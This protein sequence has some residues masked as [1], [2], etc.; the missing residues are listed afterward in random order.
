MA[1]AKYYEDNYL[2]ADERLRDIEEQ[3]M[4]NPVVKS[5]RKR[6]ANRHDVFC[7]KKGVIDIEKRG[8]LMITMAFR[9][10]LFDEQIAALKENGW[11]W[12]HH[13][14]CW[15]KAWSLSDYDFAAQFVHGKTETTC[16]ADDV[17]LDG[18]SPLT[19]EVI[20]D[21]KCPTQAEND[22]I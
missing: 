12:D 11:K 1:L 2:I 4:I 20:H 8:S 18:Y 14:K 22:V 10:H 6:K 13:R 7:S 16:E 17:Y 15:C 9:Q 21:R 19:K 3:T 5:P